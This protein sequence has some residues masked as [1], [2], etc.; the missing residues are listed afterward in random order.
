MGQAWPNS[1]M[2]RTALR[3]AADAKRLPSRGE[4]VRGKPSLVTSTLLLVAL[5][6][7]VAHWRWLR[8]RVGAAAIDT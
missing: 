6:L 8:R 5:G 2:Q 1:S 4:S 7:F 3:T